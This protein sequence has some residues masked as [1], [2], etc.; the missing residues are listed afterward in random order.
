[1]HTFC[2]NCIKEWMRQRA[3]C[4]MG[5]KPITESSLSSVPIA[6]KNMIARLKIKCDYEPQGCNAVVPLEELNAHKK[7]CLFRPVTETFHMN[8]NNNDKK[9]NYTIFFLIFFLILC[10]FKYATII[11][12]ASLLVQM[13]CYLI[14]M[15]ACGKFIYT[16]FPEITQLA[17]ISRDLILAL[18]MLFSI[19]SIIYKVLKWEIDDFFKYIR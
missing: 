2:K 13:L 4:P 17:I 6:M 18:I 16:I 15:F 3:E 19:S 1:M 5:L 11:E 7:E 9:R 10:S 14:L 12:L 8:S